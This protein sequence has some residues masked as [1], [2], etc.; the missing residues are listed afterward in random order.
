MWADHS[1]RNLIS[2]K[3]LAP[4]SIGVACGGIVNRRAVRAEISSPLISRR[5]GIETVGRGLQIGAVEAQEVKK[6]ISDDAPADCTAIVV[7]DLHGLG[8]VGTQE[9]VACIQM[10]I[11]VEQVRAAM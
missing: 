8:R 3:G 1:R 6:F 2:R 10:L 11:V 4:S 9:K 7:V 5:N